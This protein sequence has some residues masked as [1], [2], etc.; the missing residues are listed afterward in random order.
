MM[1]VL[2]WVVFFGDAAF[3]KPLGGLPPL[4]RELPSVW[5]GCLKGRETLLLLTRLLRRGLTVEWTLSSLEREIERD[6][7][8]ALKEKMSNLGEGEPMV[9]KE[10]E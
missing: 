1:V 2:R 9:E 5:C 3:L 10:G 8:R 6:L 4:L 7:E